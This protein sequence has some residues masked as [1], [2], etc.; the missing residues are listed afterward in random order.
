MN[1]IGVR[2]V[3]EMLQDAVNGVFSTR[4]KVNTVF[5]EVQGVKASEKDRDL[6]QRVRRVRWDDV[7]GAIDVLDDDLWRGENLVRRVVIDRF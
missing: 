2:G 3:R 5:P 7:D 4:K 1:A 6:S